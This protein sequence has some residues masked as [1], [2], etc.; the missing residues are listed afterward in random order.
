MRLRLEVYRFLVVVRRRLRPPEGAA[1][2]ERLTTFLL[3]TP[4]ERFLFEAE[5]LLGATLNF[6]VAGLNR[7]AVV[8]LVAT[9]LVLV[10][11]DPLEDIAA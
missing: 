3:D 1:T 4:P 7:R 10:A 9:I 8:A 5:R 6:P 2:A 11:K